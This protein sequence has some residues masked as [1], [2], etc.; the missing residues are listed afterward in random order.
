MKGRTGPL[1]GLLALTVL[2]R[3]CWLLLSPFHWD[4]FH[5]LSVLY[6]ARRGALTTPLQTFYVHLFS[7]LPAVTSGA[8]IPEQV[9]MLVGRGVMFLLSLA[10]LW[11]LYRL[12][13][14]IY[15]PQVSLACCVLYSGLSHVLEH[16]A[17]FR[18]DPLLGFGFVLSWWL[19]TCS[20]IAAAP[21][22]AGVVIS[23]MVLL[24][25][26]SAL[27]LPT[28]LLLAICWRTQLPARAPGRRCGVHDCG[29]LAGGFL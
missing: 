9:G 4:E 2:A 27:F 1:F 20:T 6:E 7:W 17:A 18:Y 26:K 23:L 5:F 15:S 8:L 12:A 11:L 3:L 22:M 21:W 14:R 10:T 29:A 19:L 24:S 28:L 16:G 13:L 25:L